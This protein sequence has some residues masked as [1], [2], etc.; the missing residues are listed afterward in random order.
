MDNML[1][2]GYLWFKTI[3]ILAVIAWVAGL[4]LL[5]RY[6]VLHSQIDPGDP[7]SAKLITMESKLRRIIITPAMI[8]TWLFG[9]LL[10]AALWPGIMSAGWF[11]VKLTLVIILSGYHGFLVKLAKEFKRGE[12]RRGHK[13][14]RMVNEIPFILTIIIVAMVVLK[15]F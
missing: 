7:T 2:D 1:A 11:H 12:R 3:H 8:A 6:F 14:Y 4:L 15:P 10:V 9:I 13:F 5:P